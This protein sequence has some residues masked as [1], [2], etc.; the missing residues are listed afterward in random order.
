M[1]DI[2]TLETAALEER[3]AEIDSVIETATIDELED[4]QEEARAIGD[5]IEAR[6]A[7]EEERRA[8]AEAVVEDVHA[9]V[10]N[11]IESVEERKMNNMEIRNTPEYID[12]YAEYIKTTNDKEC[13]A[14]LT[15]NVSGTVPVPEFVY[16]IVKTAWERNEITRLVRKTY[17]KGN[18]KVGFEIS[19]D[20]AVKHT[21][22]ANSAVS[23]E[24]LVLG[25]VNM[26]PVSF[27]KWI[28]ISDEALDLRGEAFLRYIYDEITYRIAQKIAEDLLDKIVACGT[29]ATTTQVSVASIKATQLSLSLVANALG[30][31][32][33]EAT[34]PVVVLHPATWAAIKGVQANGSY[35]YDPFE[36]LPVIKN[37]H[38]TAFSAATTGVPYMIV[39]DFGQG[40]LAN[41]PNGEGID[42]KF[43]DLSKMEYD[44]V[45][46]LG[47]E[48]AAIEPVACGAFTKIVK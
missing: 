19:A 24:N 40:A 48:Y 46:I 22:A 26:V 28:S 12:A 36:G 3:A 45:R 18:L 33:G 1:E 37:S 47:R 15:E 16:D 29:V 39:G 5:E 14:L 20:G 13:R 43:D 23:E 10:I 25:I 30:E 7:A 2:K 6:K 11:N 44:L 38:I 41:F 34:N 31:L 42:F 9:E 8:Q 35:A 32:S 4:L 21:E 17:V 27:K